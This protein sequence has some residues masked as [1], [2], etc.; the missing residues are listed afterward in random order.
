MH[1]LSQ[2]AAPLTVA[3]V[4]LP[5]APLTEAMV[6]LPSLLSPPPSPSSPLTPGHRPLAERLQH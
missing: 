3:T 5:A 6:G 2:A 4:G 1:R